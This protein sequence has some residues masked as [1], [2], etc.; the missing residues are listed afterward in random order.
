MLSMLDKNE[1]LS[2]CVA[3]L[4]VGLVT[5]RACPASG[6]AIPSD[7]SGGAGATVGD[8]N[9]V[10]LAEGELA[11]F[12]GDLWPVIRS[13]R[14]ALRAENCIEGAAADLAHAVRGFE[15]ELQ[16]DRRTAATK[17]EADQERIRVLTVALDEANPW[18]ESPAFVATVAVTATLGA[19]LIATLIIRAEAE[20]LAQL[21]GP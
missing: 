21:T 14:M 11:P 19:I 9:P 2:F 7:S 16:F 6:Q 4:L 17:R 5:L 12:D 3:T 13:L 18:Y 1:K 15:I 10:P 20:L 8:E